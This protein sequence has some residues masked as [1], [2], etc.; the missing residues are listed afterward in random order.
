M[1]R[2]KDITPQNGIGVQK[3]TTPKT[4]ALVAS[5]EEEGVR[6]LVSDDAACFSAFLLVASPEI[7]GVRALVPLFF[8]RALT[9]LFFCGIFPV[10]QG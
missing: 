7:E 2:M 8:F 10:E 5:P 6:A 3:E 4:S 9:P 1:P